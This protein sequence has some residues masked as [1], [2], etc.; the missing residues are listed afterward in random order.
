MTANIRA[1]IAGIFSVFVACSGSVQ[2]GEHVQATGGA[3]PASKG[4]EVGSGGS[5]VLTMG[6][7]SAGASAR[8]E[9]GKRQR[10]RR[11]RRNLGRVERRQLRGLERQRCR[12][13]GR[14][15]RES[16]RQFRSP[17]AARTPARGLPIAPFAAGAPAAT[18][19]SGMKRPR[20]NH[21]RS[22]PRSRTP[23]RSRLEALTAA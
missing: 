6:G 4:G 21:R 2:A 8:G 10:G 19:N 1:Q 17:W 11:A 20:T 9:R 14:P 3:A 12:K 16:A 18:A 22:K 15:R 13:R 5:S 23:A 7:A